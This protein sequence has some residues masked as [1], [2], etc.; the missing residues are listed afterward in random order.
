MKSIINDG[1]QQAQRKERSIVGNEKDEELQAVLGSHKTNIKI[2]GAGGAGN[3]TLTRM[4]EVGING[5]QT[6]AVNTDAQDLL[7]SKVDL[8]ILIGKNITNGLGAG[9]NPEIGENSAQ[10]SREEIEAA[11]KGADMVFVT[12]GLGG[13]TGTGSAPVVAEIAK[14]LGALTISVVTLPFS[15]E[16]VM[17]W[18]N[19][20]YGLEQLQQNSD[21]VIIVQNDKLLQIAPELP[22]TAAFKVADEILVNAVKGITELVTE[23]GLV[24]LDFADIRTI[25]KNGGTAMVGIGESSSDNRALEAVEQAISNPLL[26]MDITGGQSALLNVS[27]GPTM[28]LKD[29][30]IMLKV[31]AEKLDS[32]AKI[33]WGARLE[34]AMDKTV[35]ALLIVTGL[36]HKKVDLENLVLIDTERIEEKKVNPTPQPAPV[37]TPSPEPFSL[38]NIED[39]FRELTGKVE[40]S[41]HPAPA[42]SS[43]ESLYE[44]AIELDLN[45]ITTALPVTNTGLEESY[46]KN[47]RENA[48]SI[49]TSMSDASNDRGFDIRDEVKPIHE[50]K[51]PELSGADGKNKQ[52][53]SEIFEEEAQG[54]LKVLIESIES[55]DADKI[56]GK[57]LRDIKAA[58]NSLKNTAQ[59][60][61]FEM[62]DR[63][64]GTIINLIDVLL[65]RKEF[66][67]Q[68]FCRLIEEVPDTLHD[69]MA[70]VDDAVKRANDLIYKLDELIQS[71]TSH[72]NQIKD[73]IAS[74]DEKK[75]PKNVSF[76]NLNHDVNQATDSS[77]MNE[78]FQ[79]MKNLFKRN[80]TVQK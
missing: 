60:F 65:M 23:K 34:D 66:P 26:D 18:K 12:C 57:V 14:S 52:I 54:D 63:L 73:K 77:K 78:A 74:G 35:R 75:N 76:S 10:E 69:L 40:P 49:Y 32:S 7:F 43:V 70:D 1:I 36:K 64:A 38:K 55:L 2:V 9:S 53:F 45:D 37:P 61:S 21:T 20:Q 79:H 68:L 27:G 22:L 6:I 48:S 51:L 17:R 30:K 46:Q 16:G 33:I 11:L 31:I 24:N 3:N 47:Q 39:E 71:L 72:G 25:M 42:S 29:T 19:A 15:E 67:A 28:S 59:L 56:D 44:E 8:K 5:V 41:Y 80:P 50:P 13:G 4:N 62:I 58:C